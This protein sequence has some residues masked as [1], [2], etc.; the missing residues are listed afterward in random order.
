MEIIKNR[1]NLYR[2]LARLYKKEVDVNLIEAMQKMK[3]PKETSGEELSE[4]YKLLIESLENINS[5]SID[6]LDVDYAKV[7]LGAGISEG[8]AAF[9]YESVYTSRKKSMMQ[10]ARD[11]VREIYLS[12]GLIKTDEEYNYVEDHIA[13]EFEYMA[14]LCENGNLDEQ[15]NFLKTHL[16]NWIPKFCEDIEKHANTKFY[17]AIGKITKG[18]LKLDSIILE[19]MEVE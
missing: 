3:F 5:D 13:L 1:E 12:K 10:E 18:Y 19:S 6:D 14:Y 2:L 4:G 8:T 15:K 9:P 7:F 11:Q 16:L 17:K